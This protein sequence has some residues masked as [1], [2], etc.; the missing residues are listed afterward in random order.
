MT[1]NRDARLVAFRKSG[2][3]GI[4]VSGGNKSGIFVAAVKEGSPAY[5]EGLR[6]G[7]QILMVSQHNTDQGIVCYHFVNISQIVW[8]FK[9]RICSSQVRSLS[10]KKI[11]SHGMSFRTGQNHLPYS[12]PNGE[13]FVAEHIVHRPTDLCCLC[14]KK[15]IMESQIES[16][17]RTS[18]ILSLL[19][20]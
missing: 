1:C 13:L 15:M 11:I 12:Y 16:C 19:S 4:Q 17:Q 9:C 5:N 14:T 6:K 10:V 20:R 7:D 3:L 18:V 2:S 8:L